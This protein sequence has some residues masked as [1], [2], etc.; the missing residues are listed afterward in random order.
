MNGDFSRFFCLWRKSAIVSMIVMIPRAY[1]S[2]I[3][4]LNLF[5][6]DS[7]PTD[8]ISITPE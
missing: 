5:Q 4:R 2:S 1:F 7:I 8:T 3:I 6:A